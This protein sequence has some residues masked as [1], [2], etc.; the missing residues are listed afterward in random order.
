MGKVIQL[1]TD[2]PLGHC[3]LQTLHCPTEGQIVDHYRIHSRVTEFF[4][5]WYCTPND[6]DPAAEALTTL[7]DWWKSLLQLHPDT[8]S[9]P[10]HNNSSIPRQLQ[11]GLRK[12]FATKATPILQTEIR[13]AVDR[14]I[15]YDE[16]SEAIDQLRDGS[17]PGPSEATPSMLKAW[18][19]VVRRFIYDHM[20]NVWTAR[21]CPSWFRDK[22]IK[23]APKITGSNDL[24]HM[25]QISLYE[26]IRKVW[27]TTVAKR[28]HLL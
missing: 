2:Q 10:L 20:H 21:E 11:K 5:D 26:V 18:N 6:L 13:Q 27:T 7:P 14:I 19:P 16:F 15:T 4:N 25:R 22:L 24:N 17:A 8:D 1:L 28:I 23:L 3:S 9:T 12:V